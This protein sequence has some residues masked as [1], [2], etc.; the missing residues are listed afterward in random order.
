MKLNI[1]KRIG[2]VLFIVEGSQYEFSLLRRIFCT[3]LK[4]TYI[5]ERRSTLHQFIKENDIFSKIAVINT[6]ESNISSISS[7]Q[8]F[9]DDVFQILIDKHKFPVDDCAIFYL[10]DRDPKS[11]TDSELIK[12]YI[13]EL[14]NPYE[15]DELKGGQLLLSYPCIESFTVSCFFDDSFLVNEKLDEKNKVKI[16]KDL[17]SFIANHKEIQL[18]KIDE[19]TLL[20]AAK[21]FANYLEK[22]KI[23]FEIDDFSKSSEKIFDRQ[24]NNFIGKGYFDFF[25]MLTLV[26]LQL[27]LIELD[28]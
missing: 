18:N 22:E 8:D 3:V 5:E 17:K 23:D 1:G 27:G 12:K 20:H 6:K 10:F 4:Y 11:N 24:E 21:E 13:S 16:G 2:N 7:N 9:L 14:K 26:F 25:S 15:N 28:D 19:N